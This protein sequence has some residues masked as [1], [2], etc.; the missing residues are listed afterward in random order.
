MSSGDLTL[1]ADHKDATRAITHGGDSRGCCD[2]AY[3]CHFPG[4]G[5]RE[6][7]S[8]VR[9]SLPTA[10]ARA[11]P[12]SKCGS[13]AHTA[14]GVLRGSWPYQSIMLQAEYVQVPRATARNH[15]ATVRQP[16]QLLHGA[17]PGG[18]L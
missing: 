12:E 18:G 17:A 8:R 16:A 10:G 9:C 5:L 2:A 3:G 1:E 7:P 15:N 6:N 13:Q 14:C 4:Q 11:K